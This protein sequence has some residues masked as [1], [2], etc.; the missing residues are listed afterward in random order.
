MKWD[1]HHTGESDERN[2][3]TSA[4]KALDTRKKMKWTVCVLFDVRC[5]ICSYEMESHRMHEPFVAAEPNTS[6]YQMGL[7]N[8]YKKEDSVWPV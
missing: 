6:L 5:S 1:S 4:L 3:T 2:G 7:R 8:G